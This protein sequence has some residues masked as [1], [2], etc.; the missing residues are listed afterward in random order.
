MSRRSLLARILTYG[1]GMV[2]GRPALAGV[3]SR[4]SPRWDFGAAH[5]EWKP[6]EIG[7][8]DLPLVSAQVGGLPVRAVLDSGSGASIMSTALAAK[9]GLNTGEPRMIYGLSAK[10][11]VQLVRNIDV[12]LARETRRLPFAVIG[13]LSAI[14]AA[15]GRPIDMLLGTDMFTGSCIAL[16]FGKRRLAVAKSG[17]FLA[18]PGWQS[19]ALGRGS[20][21]ELFIRAAV[22]GQAP[23]PLMLDLGSSAALMLSSA[24]ARDQGLLN[25]KPLSTAALGG[26]DGVKTND[27]FTIPNINIEGLNVS[28]IP[29]L[30]MRDW[31]GTSTV[32]N[33]GFPLIAQFDVVFDVTAGF[34]WFRPLDPRHRLPMLKDRSGLGLAASPTALTVVHVAANSPAEK[35]G[36]VAGERIVAVNGHPVDANYTHGELWRARYQPAGT[37]VKLTMET[38]DVRE[39]KLADYY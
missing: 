28:N 31:L 34:V 1:T 16:D 13:D 37:L 19:V 15:F 27:I 33:I 10:A 4:G 17:T 8:G 3:A 23:V 35:A 25:G 6:L 14:S 5:L 39:L 24:Y 21:Q 30:G 11:S 12:L 9:L 38:G 36:W 22:T 32:G 2:V 29:T 7:T 20:K 18:G 26:V